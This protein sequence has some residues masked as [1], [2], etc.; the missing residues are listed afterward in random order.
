MMHSNA[1]EGQ[2]KSFH[3]ICHPCLLTL[4]DLAVI[5]QYTQ[6]DVEKDP[7]Q[8][9][10]DFVHSLNGLTSIQQDLEAHKESIRAMK[11]EGMTI[12]RKIV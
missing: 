3:H 1:A 6:K 7:I 10:T 2:G 9:A 4:H 12:L 11:K 8:L 5:S